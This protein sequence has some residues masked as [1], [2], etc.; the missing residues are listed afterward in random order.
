MEN[1]NNR[2]SK[3]IINNICFVYI[4]ISQSDKMHLDK[5]LYNVNCS[6]G[7]HF[8]PI[9][10]LIRKLYHSKKGEDLLTEVLGV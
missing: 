5:S 2:Y 4:L 6:L 7:N 8:L 3:I 10:P 9:I 1:S